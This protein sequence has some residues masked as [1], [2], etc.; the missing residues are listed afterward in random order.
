MGGAR[1]NG[2]PRPTTAGYAPEGI[3]AAANRR[4]ISTPWAHASPE[5]NIFW[6][7]GA[8]ATWRLGRNVLVPT[9]GKVS[10]V[11][12]AAFKPPILLMP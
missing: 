10:L 7:R 9:V 1:A 3:G 6:K 8:S 2:W 5:Y 12:E 11:S 4:V